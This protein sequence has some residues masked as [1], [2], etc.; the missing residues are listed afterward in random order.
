MGRKILLIAMNQAMHGNDLA[1]ALNFEITAD[2]APEWIELVPSGQ[3]VKGYDGRQWKNDRPEDIVA[4]FNADGRRI[5]IDTEHATVHKAPAGD[6]A[7]AVGWIE[8]MEVRD[9]AVWGRVAWNAAGAEA[10]GR[11]AYRYYSPVYIYEKSTGRIVALHSVGL[12]NR[13]NLRLAALN[14]QTHNPE[15]AMLKKLLKALG[16]AEDAT[17]DQAVNAVQTLQA[18]LATAA[19][20][21]KTPDLSLFVPRADYDATLA[22]ATN[23]EKALADKQAADLDEAI[24]REVDAALR[25]GKITP[26]TK[27]YY[28][29][30]CRQENGLDEFK[31]FVAAAPVIGDPS[32]TAATLPAGKATALNADQQ[33]IA[34][35]FG[36]SAEDIAKYGK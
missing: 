6:A 1:S 30:W 18:D 33:K 28:M 32:H 12:T 26:A 23:A 5:V 19:N 11:R 2:T 22:R 13:P 14:Q 10:I 31:K 9:G 4:A 24:N 15:E 35:M 36:N 34:E 21:A 17:E 20:R 16:L 27:D 29:A 3:A 8:A 25:A 7:P